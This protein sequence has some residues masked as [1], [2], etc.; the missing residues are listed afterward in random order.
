MFYSNY[1]LAKKG[2]LGK[3]WLA[4]H[5]EKRLSKSQVF[6]TDITYTVDSIIHPTEPLSLRLSGQLM[7]GLVRIFSKKINYFYVDAKD[8]I[9]KIELAAKPG[10]I[11]PGKVDIDKRH[12]EMN[13]DDTKF[14]GNV[15]AEMEYPILENL[16]FVSPLL[17]GGLRR[18]LAMPM[19][20][21]AGQIV[22]ELS[23]MDS[24]ASIEFVRYDDRPSILSA[25]R[26]SYAIE[27]KKPSSVLGSASRYD[28]MLP[29]FEEKADFSLF[30]ETQLMGG[31]VTPI[32]LEMP[33]P[34][35]EVPT[36]TP[37]IAETPTPEIAI[38]P[39]VS[40][41]AEEV[42]TRIVK[43]RKVS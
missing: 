7:L 30:E 2:P 4:A 25:G 18:E 5:F 35:I 26:A 40:P 1:I 14:Y 28:E 32:G 19:P 34:A 15:S 24:A 29:V 33:L 20:V 36:P 37:M 13:V 16:A 17:P 38:V 6:T 41:L 42:E 8:I 11:H 12:Q 22:G 31:I 21:S 10:L 43:R 27:G 3:V 23:Y 39:T 9:W